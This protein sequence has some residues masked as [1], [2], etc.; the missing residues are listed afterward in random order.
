MSPTIKSGILSVALLSGAAVCAHAQSTSIASLP[1]GAA[2]TPAPQGVVV[3]P[4]TPYVGPNA[5]KSWGAP[6]RQT[7]PVQPSAGYVGPALTVGDRGVDSD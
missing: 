3:A 1:P 2:A 6:E 4:S 5:G 7:Q